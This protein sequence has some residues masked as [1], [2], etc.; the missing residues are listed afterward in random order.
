MASVLNLSAQ[1]IEVG[2]YTF[3]DGSVY[4][5]SLYNGKPNGTGRTIFKN[6]DSYEGDYVKGTVLAFTTM[7]T[8]NVTTDSGIK[9]NATA[10]ARFSR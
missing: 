10:V 8:A 2:S 9:T 7:L 5:G 1:K 4:T 6:G 3:K